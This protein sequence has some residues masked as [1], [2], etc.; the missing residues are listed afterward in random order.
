[1][2]Q[3][4]LIICVQI[5]LS[6]IL[7]VSLGT[8]RTVLTVKGKPKY[9]AL[10]GFI[11]T[12]LWFL[13]VREALQ[14]DS[15]GIYT[16]VAYAAGFAAGTYVGGLLAGRIVQGNVSVQIV[17]SGLNEELVCAIR[18][19]GFGATVLDVHGSEFSG[20]KYM[21][22]CEIPGARLSELRAIIDAHDEHA[23]VM[24]QET[25]YVY[26]GYFLKRK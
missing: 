12:L 19:A 5:F 23:F 3:E 13:V 26:N 1:M 11:E 16:A 25:K 9:A 7:D 14:V 4:V 8:V 20:G 24:V 22:F 17:T 2:S 15:G 6:R 10:I 18:A 21:I